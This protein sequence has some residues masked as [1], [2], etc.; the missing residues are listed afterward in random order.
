[1][2]A[3]GDGANTPIR[4]GAVVG[5]RLAPRPATPARG[6]ARLAH[7][8]RRDRRPQPQGRLLRIF[9]AVRLSRWREIDAGRLAG[10]SA[11]T[12]AAYVELCRIHDG[13]FGLN[14]I[15]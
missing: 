2:I 11:M 8:R 3:L 14:R 10:N 6:G 12:R 7:A 13:R 9:A 15:L 5:G 1:M 4:R